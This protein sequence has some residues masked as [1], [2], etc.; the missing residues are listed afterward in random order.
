[1]LVAP[2]PWRTA[3]ASCTP[4]PDVLFSPPFV[5]FVPIQAY[6]AAPALSQYHSSRI[7]KLYSTPFF[8]EIIP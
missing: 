3:G 6:F 8:S 4:G 1:M 5:L 7:S 2:G